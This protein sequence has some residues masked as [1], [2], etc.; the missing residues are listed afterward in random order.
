MSK[1]PH[2]S[3]CPTFQRFR[4]QNIKSPWI[5]MYC[6]GHSELC[7]RKQMLEIG[8]EPPVT[9]MPNGNSSGALMR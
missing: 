1:C 2:L 4:I 8:K 6:M 5:K 9:L 3:I 7:K